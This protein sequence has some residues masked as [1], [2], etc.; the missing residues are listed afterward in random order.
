MQDLTKAHNFLKG[1]DTV[2]Q[3]RALQGLVLLPAGSS[4]IEKLKGL[5]Q[6]A[7]G[8]LIAESEIREATLVQ[9]GTEW[10]PCFIR[11]SQTIYKPLV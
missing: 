10:E 5:K 11:N 3:D 2:G 6:V 7:C 1:V 8:A 9:M 4:L